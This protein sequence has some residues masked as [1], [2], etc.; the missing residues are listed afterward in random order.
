MAID[1]ASTLSAITSDSFGVSHLVW[2]ENAA[3]WHAVYDGNAG[4][5]VDAQ[6]VVSGVPDNITSLN[7]VANDK[8]IGNSAP[9]LAVIWQQGDVNN[10][11]FFYSAANYDSSANLQWLETP[12]PLTVNANSNSEKFTNL[13]PQAIA[14]NNGNVFVVG[15]QV[16]LSQG[17]DQAIREDADLYYTQFTV[18]SS[19]FP[20]LS[21]GNLAAPYTP[22]V[23]IDGVNQGTTSLATTQPLAA[24]SA[25]TSSEAFSAA[26]TAN[27]SNG[28]SEWGV[29]FGPALTFSSDLY[30]SLGL[31]DY[32][33]GI[34]KHLI[35]SI[36]GGYELVG[37][38]SGS[39]VFGSASKT[40]ESALIIKAIGDVI[41]KRQQSI[42]AG[43]ANFL[44]QFPNSPFQR[45]E[46]SFEVS[47]SFESESEYS[48]KTPFELKGITDKITLSA[49]E[50]FPLFDGF[51]PGTFELLRGKV[52]FVGSA[53]ITGIL[54]IEPSS[55][56]TYSSGIQ[57]LLDTLLVQA[58]LTPVLFKSF[59]DPIEGA[60]AVL[61]ELIF[62]PFEDIL[63]GNL[64][65]L[66]NESIK[67]FLVGPTF[68]GTVNG[69]VNPTGIKWVKATLSG[70]V[71]LTFG[72]NTTEED[73]ILQ[74]PISAGVSVGPLSFDLSIKP[75]FSWT[76]PYNSSSSNTSQTA[77]AIAASPVNSLAI[78]SSI[79]NTNQ[80][81]SA[82]VNGSL[83]T[84][85]FDTPLDTSSIPSASDFT[86]QTQTINQTTP[87]NS[88]LTVFDVL[89]SNDSTTGNGVVTLR[90]N[91][92]IPYSP[93][94]QGTAANSAGELGIFVS[95]DGT[96][97]EDSSN[98]PVTDFSQVSVTNNSS[99]TFV[100][101]YNPT[102]GNAAN[103]TTTNQTFNQTSLIGNLE[104]DFAQ[105][106][107]PALALVTSSSTTEGQV[108]AVW[109]KEVQPISPIAGFVNGD[110]IYLNFVQVLN[111]ASTPTSSQFNLTVNGIASNITFG[112]VSI[113]S[114]GYVL[115][116]LNSSIQATDTVS[117]TYT[118]T[119]D[120][121]ATPTTSAIEQATSNFYLTDALGAKLW[122]PEFNLALSN[123]TGQNT[124]AA[125]NLLGGSAVIN[126]GTENLITL[127]FNQA[128]EAQNTPNPSQ[129]SVISNGAVL[130]ASDVTVEGNTVT[131]SV[132]P[133]GSNSLIG[134]GDLVTVSYTPG[135]TADQ[136]LTGNN[137]VTVTAFAQQPITTVS[138]N[139]TTS[140][141]AG[142]YT[143]GSSGL[144]H[145]QNIIGT[146]G[147]NFDPAV[148]S[149]QNGNALAVWVY[150]DSSDI[151]N[152]LVPGTIYSDDDA[153]IINDSLNASDIYFSYWNGTE[154]AI[155]A[156]L[157]AT[158]VGTDT[159]VTVAYD[160]NS[161]QYIAAWLNDQSTSTTG[162]NTATI[163][164]STYNPSTNT[165]QPIG[166]V[167][168]EA[169]PD[170]LTDLIFSSVN[171][172]VALFWSETQ[173]I[174]YSLLTAEENPYLYLRLGEINGT[175]AKNDG[176]WGAAGSGTYNG[177]LTLKETG[178]L[179]NP[180][181][182]TGDPNPAVLF[183]DGG[184]LTL[185]SAIAVS[186][187]ALSLEFWFKT[188]STPSEITNLVSLSGLLNT[189]LSVDSNNNLI[190]NF[191][192]GDSGSGNSSIATNASNN[193]LSNDTWHY[194]VGT[195]ST[196]TK[197][198]SLYL[199]AQ[200]I[201][202][203]N[204]VTFT[205]PTTSN[206]TL[207]GS[208]DSV[209]LDEI[210]LYGSV[211]DYNPPSSD[212]SL[213][214][215]ELINT[216]SGTNQIGNKYS[217]QYVE[218]LPPGPQLKYSLLN[219]TNST[220]TTQN[221]I[222]PLPQVVPTQLAD[223]NTPTFDIVSATTANSNGSI[224][225]NRQADTIYQISLTGQQTQT[226]L[227]TVID[228]EF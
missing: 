83:L 105:D 16:N 20:S 29:G 158:Q 8:L 123:T 113:G 225:P 212:Q 111:T 108:L 160:A 141:M 50:T 146:D 163:Y 34:P 213:T 124:S 68:S 30:E 195:Y 90:L 10:S 157:A 63:I 61:G 198:L 153:Q 166:E 173:P 222:D 117:L 177:N 121:A 56:D 84:L 144:S 76:T 51:V 74:F 137:G 191:G 33:D 154:W 23:V 72:F 119:P 133:T 135:S 127:I 217:T 32:L 102:S 7:L 202:T 220:W 209:Y 87:T 201:Q 115:L 3:I 4:T 178:A 167:L 82:T 21:P 99:Q 19:D 64:S 176:S 152:Q 159:N 162:K 226:I 48:G 136:N 172:Q 129:F 96:A 156:P 97:L 164:W 94:F 147:F 175:T 208:S 104:A 182:Q 95:Y 12:Q 58:A 214:G 171:G 44:K 140:L 52:N 200:L 46:P 169:S 196:Q 125:P 11:N 118:N 197:E 181:T 81:T 132:S 148:A 35:E 75:T 39:Y 216:L 77:L 62:A 40:G 92:A 110:Q 210:A 126:N 1:L 71:V 149:D 49:E 65:G 221:Q 85:I 128:L 186:G 53:G 88:G 41:N 47:L 139:P 26:A 69:E 150:A 79:S 161:N 190:L 184:N 219:T 38:L 73:T 93:Q 180:I 43:S 103:Y 101:A 134:P 106:S 91:Q 155:A 107:P 130:T 54:L 13:K 120:V 60:S 57:P 114:N 203:I 207:A 143:P 36:L 100:A 206:L 31:V 122:V 194:V 138:L 109:S 15:Q 151:P 86:V 187:S 227:N 228:C 218:P 37:T 211:L 215:L 188:P 89:V 98:N 59:D 170:P 28:S 18:N 5:W 42:S 17:A 14:D 27:S 131:F 25:F 9:G 24:Y 112:N 45:P 165:W 55:S 199:N 2:V 224:S 168:S 142:L 183:A 116:N 192:L 80:I 78:A 67:E 22:P 193:P 145:F 189:T 205:L 174:S 70:G 185:N 6:Q 66:G 204:D 179:E 223:A